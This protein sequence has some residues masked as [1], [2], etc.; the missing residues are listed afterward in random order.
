MV[1]CKCFEKECANLK[2]Q[3]STNHHKKQVLS[4]NKLESS[5]YSSSFFSQARR[6]RYLLVRPVKLRFSVVLFQVY[7]HPTIAGRSLS[8]TLPVR[9]SS[10]AP[11]LPKKALGLSQRFGS[12]LFKITKSRAFTLL[13]FGGAGVVGKA[14]REV[15]MDA[16]TT[17]CADDKEYADKDKGYA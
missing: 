17:Q 7:R 5:P 9:L 11:C 8:P 14:V 4:K 12:L 13:G 1:L 2:H 15:D 16:R 3:C 10:F 6:L